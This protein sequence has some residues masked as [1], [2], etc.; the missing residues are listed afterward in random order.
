M[1]KIILLLQKVHDV[2]VIAS[3]IKNENVYIYRQNLER[4]E[5]RDLKVCPNGKTSSPHWG[6]PGRRPG[7]SGMRKA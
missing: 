5:F 4:S 3:K 7:Q 2:N 1:D 6:A